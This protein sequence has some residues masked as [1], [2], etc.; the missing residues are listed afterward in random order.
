MSFP[1]DNEY[2]YVLENEWDRAERRLRTLEATYDPVTERRLAARGVAEGWN[3]LEVGAG[4]GSITRWLSAQ[5]GPTGTV[6]AADIDVRHLTDMPGN[7]LVRQLDV[8]TEPLPENAFDLIHTRLVLN[9]LPEREKVLDKLIQALRPGGWLVVE[10]GDTFA[11]G[12]SVDE[13]EDHTRAMRAW[14]AAIA[15]AIDVDLGRR[16]PRM[17]SERGLADIGVE[18][19]VPF[20]EG[21]SPGAEFTLLTFDQMNERAGGNLLD[22][23]TLARWKD[24]LGRPGRWFASLALI[25]TWGRRAG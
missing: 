9:H 2:V 22:A 13:E 24:M 19:E 1:A 5:V 21:G 7:V 20:V 15:V 18:C 16:L 6:V 11:T 8:Q 3:C 10:E 4:A 25:T 14:Q 12:G 17:F 23:E